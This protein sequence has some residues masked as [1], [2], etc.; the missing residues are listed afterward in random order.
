[1]NDGGAWI[2]KAFY[3]TTSEFGWEIDHLVPVAQGGQ[4]NLSNLQPLHWQNNRGKGDN[5][6]RWECTRPGKS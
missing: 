5:Y 3:G 2:E 4:D 1:M 6:P